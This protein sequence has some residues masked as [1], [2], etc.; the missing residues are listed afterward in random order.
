MRSLEAY[1]ATIDE[2][3][4]LIVSPDS[5]FFKYLDANGK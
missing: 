3:T 1:R 2:N 5:E 4:T